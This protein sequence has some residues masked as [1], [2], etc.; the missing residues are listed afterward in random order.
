MWQIFDGEKISET[1]LRILPKPSIEKIQQTLSVKSTEH[2]EISQT[3]SSKLEY[4]A[5]VD[6]IPAIGP[7]PSDQSISL[8]SV[9]LRLMEDAII[10]K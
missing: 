6:E 8:L 1:A 7:T 10:E 3:L 5:F 9:A 2:A 4:L